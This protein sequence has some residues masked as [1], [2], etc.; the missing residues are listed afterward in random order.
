ME[1]KLKNHNRRKNFYL[2]MLLKISSKQYNNR[3]IDKDAPSLYASLVT[4]KSSVVQNIQNK[5]LVLNTN[6]TISSSTIYKRK[7]KNQINYLK[8]LDNTTIF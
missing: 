4:Y 6:S 2:L 1:K 7:S 5:S 8:Y 3:F